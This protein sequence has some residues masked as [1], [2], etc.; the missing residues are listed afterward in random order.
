MRALSLEG[1]TV[2]FGAVEALRDVDLAMDPGRVVMLAGPNGCGKSTLMGVLLGLVRPDGGRM[3]VDGAVTRPDERFRT[4]LGYLPEA[5]A[6]AP[7]LNARQILGFFARARGVPGARVDEALARVRLDD[8]SRRAV[9]GFSRGMLQ[10]LGV[11][12]ATIA[13]PELLVL[14][15]PTGGLDQAGLAVL[16]EIIAEYRERGRFVLLASH[17]LAIM[18]TRV[19]HVVMMSDGR[20]HAAGSP[21]DLRRRVDLPVRV[22][23]EI[24]DPEAMDPFVS[25]LEGRAP[26][27]LRRNGRSVVAETTPEKLMGILE[28]PSGLEHA[29]ASV[30]VVEP[31]FDAVYD[32]V[33]R[34]GD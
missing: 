13:E 18:E 29:V 21:A 32:A 12:V 26:A 34:E 8:A 9:R 14:D 5:V 30:R 10:R 6:F 19:D 23:F 31:G 28:I 3:V 24:S 11:A 7:N 27:G 16:S 1:I 15:E 33:L 22:H 25:A 2:R 20:V 17:D 4:R